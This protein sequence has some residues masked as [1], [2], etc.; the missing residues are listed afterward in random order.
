MPTSIC[1]ASARRSVGSLGA[2]RPRLRAAVIF[3]ALLVSLAFAGSAMAA[4]SSK[5]TVYRVNGWGN[6]MITSTPNGM[7]CA[8]L[9]EGSFANGSNVMLTAVPAAGSTFTGWGDAC[10]GTSVT[11]TV[12]MSAATRVTATFDL[13]SPVRLDVA[14]TGSSGFVFGSSAFIRCGGDSFYSCWAYLAAGSDVTLQAV[15]DDH[16]V[17]TGWSG[18]C[19]GSAEFCVVSMSEAKSVTASFTPLLRAMV[20]HEGPGLGSVTSSPGGIHC[21]GGAVCEAEFVSGTV[22]TLTAVANPGSIFAGWSG[23]CT[24]T[25]PTCTVSMDAEHWVTAKFAWAP[26]HFS[27]T[28]A[29]SGSGSVTSNLDG[30]D[31]GA[32][33]EGDLPATKTI[34]LTAAAASGSVFAGW[35]GVCNGTSFTCTFSLWRDPESVSATFDLAPSEPVVPPAPA[36]DE[37]SPPP[38]APE[39]A[40]ALV[41]PGGIV[42]APVAASPV[43]PAPRAKAR[44]ALR[45]RPTLSGRARV[46]ATLVCTRGTWNG[47]P[48]GYVF[49]WRRDGKVIRHGSRHLVRTADRG[50]ALRCAVTAR[51]T[52]GASTVASGAVRIPG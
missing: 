5:L 49:T 2:A 24:G 19:S 9:C 16:S 26:V 14:T 20:H 46:G 29:G 50:H 45:V 1:I 41:T 37:T 33:C 38:P 31:C 28:K 39:A 36:P 12:A 17:F 10:S 3:L 35:S 15:P 25:S 32:T 52:A 8:T 4:G 44:P 7:A 48:S 43:V 30:I 27:V 42:Q 47:N 40:L 11:C 13:V 21:G 18:A 34:T 23:P 22:L 6:G 51:N